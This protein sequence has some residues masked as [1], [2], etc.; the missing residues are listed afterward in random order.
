MNKISI[1][2][3]PEGKFIDEPVYLDNKYI[4]LSPDIEVT[5]ELK[6]LLGKWKYKIVYSDGT[7]QDAPPINRE[8]A[9]KGEISLLDKSIKEQEEEKAVSKFFDSCVEFL[10]SYFN[11][12]IQV[13]VL[14]INSLSEKVKEILSQIHEH[15]SLLLSLSSEDLSAKDPDHYLA[16]HSVKT[17]ILSLAIGEFIKLP[18]H[19]L[20]ELGIGSL[21][22]ELGMLLLP[23]NIYR[24]NRILS[25]RERQ[26]IR[27]HP[28]ITY[29]ALKKAEYPSP[30]YLAVLEHHEHIDGTGYPQRIDGSKISLYGKIIAVS[31]AFCAATSKREYRKGKDGHNGIMDLLKGKGK[32]YDETILRALVFVLS[33]YPVGTYVILTNGMKGI[34]IKTNI[35]APKSPTLKLLTDE[36]GVPYAHKPIL[37]IN[38]DEDLQII[39]SMSKEEISELKLLFS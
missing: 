35:K 11:Q 31:S 18:P 6:S 12:F 33:V 38:S 36:N 8:I 22:H 34:V 29:K 1:E 16:V 39:R 30:I 27:T 2:S 17:T 20:I 14:P 37:Q 10:D 21:L 24:N 19:K 32:K 4:L 7:P 3:L 23:P 13:N 28:V 5:Q 26:M 15:R 9:G 25:D